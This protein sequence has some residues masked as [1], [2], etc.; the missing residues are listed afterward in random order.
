MLAG[1]AAR[2][3]WPLN[4][5]GIFLNHG[6]YGAVPHIVASARQSWQAIFADNPDRFLRDLYPAALVR[7]RH[8]LAGFVGCVP[9]HLALVENATSGI[10]TIINS[11]MMGGFFNRHSVIVHTSHIYNAVRIILA[12]AAQIT[13]ARL[14]QINLPAAPQSF[15]ESPARILD[16]LAAVLA[17]KPPL[18]VVDHIASPTA[19]LLPIAEIVALAR[20]HGVPVLVDGAHAPGMMPLDLAVLAAD[21]YV[22][23]CHKWLCAVPGTAFIAI[24]PRWHDLIRPLVPSHDYHAA[25]PHC[26]DW[27][28]TRDVSGW[29]ALPDAVA[30]RRQ[31]PDD[32]VLK[33]GTEI[34]NAADQILVPVTPDWGR[35]LMGCYDLGPGNAAHAAAIWQMLRDE[36][37][38][39]AAIIPFDQRLLLRI[40]AFIYNDSN[41]IAVLA[42]SLPHILT[43]VLS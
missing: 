6:S 43:K 22:G 17:T 12:Q 27:I 8:A 5:C 10:Q 36:C 34:L 3:L 41:D 24:D 13:G 1:K 29:L 16:A 26:F 35:G 21:F 9:E 40:S 31:W 25:Y 19:L 2:C 4:P 14:Q 20:A 28:G 11:L 37:G 33:H 42:Q 32:V 23:N 15:P 18:L 30:F 7:A 38:I 39:E